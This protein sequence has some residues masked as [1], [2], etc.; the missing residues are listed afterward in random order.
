MEYA[1][2]DKLFG[3]DPKDE[4][5]PKVAKCI[6]HKFGPSGSIMRHDALCVL[7]LNIM[8]EKIFAF[9]WYWWVSCKNIGV[10]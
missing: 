5:F 3:H 1:K 10:L 6:F 2:Q 4:I 7:P 8:N 9:L